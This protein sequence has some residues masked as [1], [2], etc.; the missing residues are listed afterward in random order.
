MIQMRVVILSGQSLFAQGIASR[1]EQYLESVELEVMLPRQSDV[2]NRMA[3]VR[4]SVVILDPSDTEVA[5]FCSLD[6]LLLS[7]SQ[8]K[9]ICLDPE[10]GHMQVVT[11]EQHAAGSIRDLAKVI[12][13]SI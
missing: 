12:D 4:P 9:V 7:F 1:L 3:A 13:Q 8:L 5:Q 11:S 6:Q 10:Q 2:I